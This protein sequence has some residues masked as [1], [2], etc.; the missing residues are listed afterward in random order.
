[1]NSKADGR[2]SALG[3]SS[4]QVAFME[5]AQQYGGANEVVVAT[6]LLHQALLV[7]GGEKCQT[8]GDLIDMQLGLIPPG[9]SCSSALMDSELP[10]SSYN[11]RL[12]RQSLKR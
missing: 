9:K 7:F 5:E 4:S 12:W 1:M 3:V 10:L 8:P 11:L 2:V 6:R